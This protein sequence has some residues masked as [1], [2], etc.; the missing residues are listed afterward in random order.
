T[1]KCWGSDDYGV[2]GQDGAH[3]D[4]SDPGLIGPI[5]FGDD[6]K[7]VQLSAGWRHVCVLFEDARARCWGNNESGQLGQGNVDD[8]GDDPG[9]SLNSLEDI[10]LEDVIRVSAGVSNTCVIVREG[11]G[12]GG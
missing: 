11:E 8:Y 10:A 12:A 1:V 5:D 3:A 2:L 4:V 9:E 6:R 7:V